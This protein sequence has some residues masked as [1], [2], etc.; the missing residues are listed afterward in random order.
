MNNL[1]LDNR[2]LK[3]FARSNNPH[4][5]HQPEQCLG[6]FPL[7]VGHLSNPCEV[8]HQPHKPILIAR[9]IEIS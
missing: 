3:D 8:R 7:D 6:P 9:K 2:T 5:L 1:K 4:R